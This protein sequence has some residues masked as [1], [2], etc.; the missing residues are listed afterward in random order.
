MTTAEILSE[1]PTLTTEERWLI[2]ERIR[3]LNEVTDEVENCRRSVDE[4]FL[5]LDQMEAHDA[6]NQA[7]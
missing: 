4:A 6:T 7:G 5:M 1:L 3:E 2:Y